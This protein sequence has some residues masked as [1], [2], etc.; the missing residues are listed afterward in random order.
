MACQCIADA[1]LF[2]IVSALNKSGRLGQ[3]VTETHL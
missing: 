3:N 2:S 1:E